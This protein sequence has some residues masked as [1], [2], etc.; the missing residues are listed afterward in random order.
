MRRNAL[1][2]LI[3]LS[4]LFNVCF[5]AGFLYV[6]QVITALST[7]EGRIELIGKR[8]GVAP[9]ARAAC[10]TIEQERITERKRILASEEKGLDSF[11]AETVKDQPDMERL[12]TMVDA[13]MVLHRR[14]LLNDL[15]HFMRIAAHLTPEQ[16]RTMANIIRG[17][18][19][20]AE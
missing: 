13:G 17:E 14:L 5:V 15:E 16:R 8:M 6:R 9:P 3:A 19:L 1:R 4:L 10:V 11:F 18:D 20:F 12:R 7:P 2:L